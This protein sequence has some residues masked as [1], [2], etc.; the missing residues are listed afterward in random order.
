MMTKFAGGAYLI[1]LVVYAVVIPNAADDKERLKISYGSP[2]CRVEGVAE[3]EAACL[4][5]ESRL[6]GGSGNVS[7]AECRERAVA[8]FCGLINDG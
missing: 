8:E 7:P 1:A 4:V 3:K 2:D 6:S 5:G